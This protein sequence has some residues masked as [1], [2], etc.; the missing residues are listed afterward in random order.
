MSKTII[1]VYALLITA[2]ASLQTPIAMAPLAKGQTREGHEAHGQ[3]W[4]IATQGEAASRAGAKMFELGGNAVDAAVAI[5]FVISVERPQSTGIGGGGFMLVHLP[6]QD[7]PVA[8]DFREKAPAKAHATMYL[9]KDGKVVE[10]KSIDGIF[11]VGVPGLVAGVLEVH[12]RY[13]L[14]ELADVLKPA[15][16]LAR[17][18]FKIYPELALAIKARAPVMTKF[19]DSKKIFYNSDSSPKKEGDVLVQADLAQTLEAIAKKGHDGFYKGN[20]AKALIAENKR[21]GGLMTQADLDAYDV[22]VREPVHGVYNNHDVYSMAPPSSGGV[23]VIQILNTV[24]TD[25]LRRFGVQ[26]PRSV[27]LIASAMQQAFADR[28][29]HLGDSDYVKVPVKELT[30]KDYAH[31]VRTRIPNDRAL[32]REEVKASNFEFKDHDETT[33]FSVMDAEGMVVVSTQTINGWFGSGVVA[34]GTGI[35]LNNE[36]DDFATKAG[37]S[38]L[39]GAIG[40]DKNLV[41]PGKRPLSSMSPTIVLR[42]GKPVLALGTPSGTRILTCVAQTLLNRIE[43][44][45]PLWESVAALRYH[46]QWAPDQLRFEEVV[47]PERLESKLKAMGHNIV[48]KDLGCKI[49]AVERDGSEIHAVSDPRGEGRALAN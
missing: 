41:A 45:L 10:K 44:G 46:Q 11:S 2:C 49:Q 26:D 42:Y 19:K 16:E 22:K 43:F 40:G 14:L 7:K 29:T 48:Q 23:H 12:K 15:I 33:H 24:E 13:G 37:A 3:Q 17:N 20:V 25:N 39:F 32:K 18:G 27:H 8:F 38:N 21:Q 34:Q 6:G 30:S 1:L 35:V 9:D 47:I 36:M 28:A 5:S 4:G 31:Q